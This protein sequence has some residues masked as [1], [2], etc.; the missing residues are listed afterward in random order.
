MQSIFTLAFSI[1]IHHFLIVADSDDTL[2][3]VL[4]DLQIP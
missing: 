1:H 4:D 2:Y 3:V